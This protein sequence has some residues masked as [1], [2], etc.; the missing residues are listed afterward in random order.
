[1]IE[2]AQAQ[3]P[4]GL[5]TAGDQAVVGVHAHVPTLCQVALVLRAFDLG[6]AQAVG[7]FEA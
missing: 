3:F 4:F 1:M 5:E 6:V 7:F 2:L